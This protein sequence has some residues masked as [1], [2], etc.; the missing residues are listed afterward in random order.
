M[1]QAKDFTSL[2]TG[3]YGPWIIGIGVAIVGILIGIICNY[4]LRHLPYKK[5]PLLTNSEYIF[6][7]EMY[8]KMKKA[9]VIVCPKVRMEDFLTVNVSAQKKGKRQAFRNRIKSRHIDFILCDKD[10]NMIAGVELDD[11][12]HK[13]NVSTIEGDALK[14][15]IFKD[16]GVRLF[17]VP[18]SKEGY[19]EAIDNIINTL[20]RTGQI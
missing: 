2:F 17:R 16:I 6:W 4:R 13:Y 8:P 15:Q 12:S 1:T 9:G 7:K 3:E 19:A 11:K 14:N 20:R 5:R 10:L 18:T